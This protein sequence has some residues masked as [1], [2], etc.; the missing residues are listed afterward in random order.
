M[1][2]GILIAF[3]GLDGSGKSVQAKM[4]YDE[5]VRRGRKCILTHEPTDRDLGMQIKRNVVDGTLDLSNMT[6][7]ILFTADRSDHVHKV[8]GPALEDR[9]AVIADRY[10][11]STLAY[12]RATGLELEWLSD[13]NSVFPKPDATF[14][15]KVPPGI[16]AK[17]RGQRGIAQRSLEDLKIQERV[18]D[19]YMEIESKYSYSGWFTVDASGLVDDVFKLVMGRLEGILGETK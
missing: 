16:A 11:W 9:V 12:G 5:L 7:Q 4:V 19:A 13:M 3:E 8:I 14:W 17:R 2:K 18:N 6:L 15:L 10:Y 1:A